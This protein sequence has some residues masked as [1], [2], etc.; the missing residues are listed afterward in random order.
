MRTTI[1]LD[2]GLVKELKKAKE[3]PRQTYKELLMKMLSTF[4]S[5]KS[6]TSSGSGA[7]TIQDIKMKE[8]WGGIE[9]DIWD[10]L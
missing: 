2:K 10:K 4:K 1:I 7:Q 6:A 8:L 9:D 3:Y 5:F